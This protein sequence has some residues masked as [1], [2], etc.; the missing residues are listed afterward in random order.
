MGR[1]GRHGCKATFGPWLLALSDR[2]LVSHPGWSRITRSV[3]RTVGGLPVARAL[4]S[5]RR[6]ASEGVGVV[7]LTERVPVLRLWVAAG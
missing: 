4:S 1:V 2:A 6:A 7:L 5:L 3:F